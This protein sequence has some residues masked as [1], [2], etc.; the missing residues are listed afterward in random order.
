MDPLKIV[1]LYIETDFRGPRR[2]E[3]RVVYLLEI[4]TGKGE[5]AK[6]AVIPIQETT[7]HHMVITA[8]EEA[9]RRITESCQIELW[10]CDR[11][12]AGAIEGGLLQQWWIRGWKTA[13][14]NPVTDAVLWESIAG[15]LSKH[16]ISV[17]L[18]EFHEYRLL[19]QEEIRKHKRDKRKDKVLIDWSNCEERIKKGDPYEQQL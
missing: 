3:G 12:V 19:M 18:G 15:N 7:E 10:L 4:K 11:Y 2:Q 14:G 1:N 16:V 6:G 17:H 9:L 8:L 5:R 13:R